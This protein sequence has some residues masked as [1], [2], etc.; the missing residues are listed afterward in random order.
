MFSFSV[1]LG[2]DYPSLCE[3]GFGSERLA[4]F[5]SHE[6]FVVATTKTEANRTEW[7]KSK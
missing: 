2:L 3:F 1:S 4:E 7:I 6:V 5:I